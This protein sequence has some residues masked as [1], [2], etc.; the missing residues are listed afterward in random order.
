MYVC[1]YVCMYVQIVVFCVVTPRSYVV[2]YR[3]FGEIC[4]LSLHMAS[5][6]RHEYSSLWKFQI[7]HVC[8]F[9]VQKSWTDPD[10]MCQCVFTLNVMGRIF[11]GL[12]LFTTT[13]DTKISTVIPLWLSFIWIFATWNYIG[14]ITKYVL[15]WSPNQG[16]LPNVCGSRS[17][18]R[19]A[20]V[21]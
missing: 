15:D 7:S 18:L 5:R 2:G 10:D 4:C 8:I 21:R 20:K 9:Y 12:S 11:L 13:N 14:N 19:K 16:V 6:L 1:M 17:P 3:R